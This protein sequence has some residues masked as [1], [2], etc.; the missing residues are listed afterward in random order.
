[1]QLTNSSKLGLAYF[2]YFA[3]L[4]IFVPYLPMFLDG[5][6]FNSYQIGVLLAIVTAARIVGPS[7]WAMVV[8]RCGD[9]VSVMRLGAILA[10]MGWAVSYFDVGYWPLVAAM[11]L[12]SLFWTAILPQLEVSAFH[13]LKND[14]KIYGRIRSFG[15]VGYILVVMLGGWLLQHLGSEFLP[16][17]A[18]VFLALLLWTLWLL[19]SF[20]IKSQPEAASIRF[21]S[22]FR[23]KTFLT[24]MGATFLMQLGFAPF[25]GFFMLYCRDLGYSGSF[26]GLMIAIAVLA[27]IVAF[28]FAGSILQRVHYRKLLMFCYGVTV[29]R[30]L[31][32]AFLAA[33]WY[34][35]AFSMSFH[36]ASFALAHSAAMQFVQNFFPPQQRSRGQA[37]YAGVV[38]GGGGAIGAYFAGLIWADGAGSTWTFCASAV[39]AAGACYLAWSLPR[40][41]APAS[42]VAG[43]QKPT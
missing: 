30:W 10:A 35:L 9:P 14:N 15:S 11:A 20:S 40:Q 12:Y 33:D 26:S 34:W 41:N 18:S 29:V 38:Y 27:E 36:A 7:A 31:I 1:M 32:V 19:P 2:A 17:S 39:A 3:V 22:L 8:E 25:Y 28:F 42:A 13:F 6:G 5:R 24:F 37:L 16:W 43:Q 21:R 4:G 23:H